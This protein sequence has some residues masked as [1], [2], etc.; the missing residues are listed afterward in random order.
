VVGQAPSAGLVS[1]PLTAL[2]LLNLRETRRIV[3]DDP[4]RVFA[5]CAGFI[6]DHVRRA[7]SSS[8]PTG[9][10]FPSS[11]S[12]R[13]SSGI[14]S[15]STPPSCH[16]TSPE[17]FKAWR[18]VV[19]TRESRAY[20]V[21]TETFGSRW[22]F[23]D[24][25]Y[26]EFLDRAA[27]DPTFHSA[28]STPDC[29]VYSLSA[30]EEEPSLRIGSWTAADG[31]RTVVMPREFVDAGR[32]AGASATRN[33]KGE[34]CARLTGAIQNAVPGSALLHVSTDDTIRITLN[35]A[36]VL[37]SATAP[38]PTIDEVLQRQRRG[39]PAHERSFGI[40]LVA[41]YNEVALDTCRNGL[42]WGF[43]LRGTNG[44]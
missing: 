39:A 36:M 37:D 15:D 43:S 35:G 44:P 23:A 7:R 5:A 30:P 32:L 26:E 20:D 34:P 8:R 6:H 13:R 19:E 25:G 18:D 11:S 31:T 29:T 10:S 12:R 38:P 42:T 41:G 9:T 14:W 33:D 17:R 21:I 3:A 40:T 2:G 24:A 16:A 1:P 28:I 4:G 27:Q 22:V